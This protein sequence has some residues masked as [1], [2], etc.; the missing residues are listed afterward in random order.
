MKPSRIAFAA[1][2]VLGIG[3]SGRALWQTANP[4][5]PAEAYRALFEDHCLTR[6]AKVQGGSDPFSGLVNN[7]KRIT[8]L[9]SAGL[10]A[11]QTRQTCE[12]KDATRLMTVA[13]RDAV[14]ASIVT[15]IK[16][17]LSDLKEE[18]TPQEGS[19]H[20]AFTTGSQDRKWGVTLLRQK[21]DSNDVMQMTIT[22]LAVPRP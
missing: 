2:L 10:Q 3:L 16:A 19:L 17:Q 22:Q 8:R 6:L 18:S 14:E 20:R 12:V 21:P 7:E 13:Q 9:D 11:V 4:P 5:A 15:L 1:A